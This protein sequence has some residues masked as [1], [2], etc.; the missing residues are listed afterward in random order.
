MPS[1]PT[2]FADNWAYLKTEL[3]WLERLLMLAIARQRQDNKDIDRVAQ[4][5]ADRATSHWWKGIISTGR[6]PGYDDYRGPLSTQGYPGRSQS[7]PGKSAASKP[8]GYQKQIEARIR[9]S[10]GAGIVLGLPTV[11]DRFG[12]T[13]IE[14]NLILFALAPE[15]NRRYSRLYRYLQPDHDSAWNSL[16]SLDLVLR[17]LCRNDIEWRRGR[18]QL[19]NPN[20]L[21]WQQVIQPRLETSLTL[22]DTPLRLPNPLLNYLLAEQP[23]LQTLEHWPG[24][25]QAN[26]VDPLGCTICHPEHCW[27]NLVLPANQRARLQTLCNQVRI[28]KNALDCPTH[29]HNGGK[30]L[31]L[32]G[33]SGTGK[34]AIAH[35]IAHDLNQSL[36]VIDLATISPESHIELW[37]YNRVLTAP[38][39]LIESAQRWFGRHPYMDSSLVWKGIQQ[40]RAQGGVTLLIT[41]YNQ[42]IRPRWRQQ[43]DIEL[44]LT[45]PDKRARQRLWQVAI[46]PEI[47][48]SRTIPWSSLAAQF[49]LTGGEIHQIMQ[50]AIAQM[51]RKNASK[52]TLT[53]IKTALA[54]YGHHFA[55]KPSS[56]R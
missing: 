49:P 42:S 39:L 50:T 9:A 5:A 18:A 22:L 2:P 12:L 17:L 46:P 8:S 26:A 14:K 23:Q 55:S 37:Q 21:V 41:P 40:R 35:G 31:L 53:H 43:C 30:L 54:Q 6:P 11:C 16:P 25:G 3:N 28:H 38:I 10:R 29:S 36:M 20:G 33:P 44:N 52:L 51:A 34:T 4:T 48:I 56:S 24:E 19:A 1:E 32:T 45:T 13:P 47:A 15:V 7:G 27:D